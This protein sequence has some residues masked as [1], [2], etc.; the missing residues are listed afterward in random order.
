[1]PPRCILF[2]GPLGPLLPFRPRS[3]RTAL[4][5]AWCSL[6]ALGAVEPYFV[7]CPGTLWWV[8]RYPFEGEED[9]DPWVHRRDFKFLHGVVSSVLEEH[10]LCI[11]LACSFDCFPCE[12][13]DAAGV[14]VFLPFQAE[15]AHCSF[16]DQGY[17]TACVQQCPDLVSY[18]ALV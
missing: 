17:R 1:M 18:I 8:R 11:I 9:V 5:R 14:L 4:L 13:F 6:Q 3:G 15:P 16:V 7:V 12:I 2:S 10:R